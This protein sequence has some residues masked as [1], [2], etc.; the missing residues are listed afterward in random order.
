[1]L[2]HVTG[3]VQDPK[4]YGHYQTIVFTDRDKLI[5]RHSSQVIMFPANKCLSTAY[6]VVDVINRLEQQ[7]EF[8]SLD[9]IVQLSA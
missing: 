2:E 3:F 5:W 9:G 6:V 1:M 4:A 8:L 7:T